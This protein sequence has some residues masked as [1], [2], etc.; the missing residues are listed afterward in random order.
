MKKLSETTSR[1]PEQEKKEEVSE[2]PPAA[3][4]LHI[5]ELTKILRYR[6]KLIALVTAVIA[7]GTT[8]GHFIYLPK[9]TSVAVLNVQQQQSNSPADMFGSFAGKASSNVETINNYLHYLKSEGFFLSLAESLKFNENYNKLIL[10]TPHELSIFRKTFWLRIKAQYFPRISKDVLGSQAIEPVLIRVE[11][12]ANILKQLMTFEASGDK[13]SLISIKVTSFDPYTAML[14]AN[15]AAKE[16]LRLT[17]EQDQEELKQVDNFVRERLAETTARLKESELQ[18]INFKKRHNILGATTQNSAAA[19]QLRLAEGQLVPARL[20]YDENEKLIEYHEKWLNTLEKRAAEGGGA[21][22][23]SNFNMESTTLR[24]KFDDLHKQKR[25][26]KSQGYDENDWRVKEVTIAINEVAAQL[27]PS[28]EEDVPITII[29]PQASRIK[30]KEL[31][32]VNRL[33]STKIAALSASREKSL[34]GLSGVPQ[35]ELEL[36]KLQRGM[37]LELDTY[38]SLKKK[39]SQ[40]EIQQISM[41]KNV[42]AEEASSLPSPHPRANLFLK[43]LFSC[44]IGLF[45]GS[46]LAVLL[47]FVDSSVRYRADL[48]D[49]HLR[50]LGEIPNI[51][52][53]K[54]KG[55]PDLSISRS[56]FLVTKSNPDS[57]EAMAFKYVRTRIATIK[58][59]SDKQIQSVTVTSAENGDGKSLFSANMAICFAQMGKKTVLVDADLRKPSQ[60]WYFDYQ[61]N[62][63][64]SSLLSL[65]CF[66]DDIIIRNVTRNLDIIPAGITNQNPTELIG[67]DKFNLLLR[68]LK[69]HYDYIILDCPPANAMVDAA[70]AASLTDCVIMIASYRKTKKEALLAAHRRVQQIAHKSVYGV[71]NNVDRVEDFLSYYA[72]PYVMAKVEIMKAREAES[73]PAVLKKFQEN[74]ERKTGT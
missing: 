72:Y 26:L 52:T 41:K 9:Y 32:E 29:N 25:L 57:M 53:D 20:A 12:V 16:F 15:V 43:I 56:D 14:I 35:T 65:K 17:S 36:L 44:L 6:R 37:E 3:E 64:L 61:R 21:A 5:S 70:I 13:I 69:Q 30:I 10:T 73:N 24:Q 54:D 22:Y 51:K 42:R 55:L 60:L 67:G 63:G 45:I 23:D 71:L 1:D 48:E 46:L 47:E 2:T 4:Y 58:S 11:Q 59:D 50:L 7:V 62:E 19:D 31:K 8:V 38:Q 74:L 33:L 34:V 18:L 39:Q 40:V 27:K 49:C 68:H 28:S 66:L